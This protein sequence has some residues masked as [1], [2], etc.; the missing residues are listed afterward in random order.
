MAVVELRGGGLGGEA[1][2]GDTRLMLACGTFCCF[3]GRFLFSSEKNN[4][5]EYRKAML[6]SS[7]IKPS[8]DCS[9]A[10]STHAK[11]DPT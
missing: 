1:R 9:S 7:G 5:K 6:L 4:I 10:L 2:V 3:G 8:A 11:H